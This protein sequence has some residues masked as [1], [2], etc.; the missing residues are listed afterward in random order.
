MRTRLFS[1]NSA[2]NSL[3]HRR[4][5]AH[6]AAAD[7]VVEAIGG[8]R[9]AEAEEQQRAHLAIELARLGEFDLEALDIGREAGFVG[10]NVGHG[11][12]RSEQCAH[13]TTYFAIYPTRA[14]R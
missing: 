4:R 5:R 10:E 1:R 14:A 7:Q 13:N 8:R 12:V 2:Q 9:D 3:K 6:G 11:R